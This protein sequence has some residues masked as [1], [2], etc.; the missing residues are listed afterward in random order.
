ML[1]ISFLWPPGPLGPLPEHPVLRL[2]HPALEPRE[3]ASEDGRWIDRGEGRKGLYSWIQVIGLTTYQLPLLQAGG[4][5]HC[6]A[7]CRSQW[8]KTP[9]F[10]FTLSFSGRPRW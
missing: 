1:P 7:Q 10:T 6:L 2:R 5:G 4:T 9:L 8:S 3:G